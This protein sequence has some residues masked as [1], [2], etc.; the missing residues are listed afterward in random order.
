MLIDDKCQIM[1]TLCVKISGEFLPIRLIYS[2]TTDRCHPKVKFSDLL[3]I[4]HSF[5]HWYN[6]CIII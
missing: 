3:H 2:G 1:G 5:N 6:G 4:T